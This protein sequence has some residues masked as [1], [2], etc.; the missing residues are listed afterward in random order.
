MPSWEVHF[1]LNLQ[2][3]DRRVI[4]DLARIHA[5]AGVIRGIPIPPR[6]Q[7]NLDRLNIL[8]AVRGT[9]GIEGT[10]LSEEEVSLVL[11]S[12][13]D[14]PVLGPGRERDEQETKN[15]EALMLYVGEYVRNNPNAPISEALILKFHR[16]LTQKINYLHN[17][18]ESMSADTILSP[19]IS[20]RI[21]PSIC[22]T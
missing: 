14:V 16:I 12:P 17:D 22:T 15:A 6:V 21:A 4:Q 13:P 5:L 8:R 19:A 2:V 20:I 11:D 18:P 7:R 1:N 3:N 9:T 10:E